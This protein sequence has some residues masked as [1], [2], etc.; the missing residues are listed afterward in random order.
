MKIL[1]INDYATPTGGAEI[2][3]CKVKAGKPCYLNGCLPLRDFL[4]LMVQKKL[5]S[6]KYSVFNLMVANSEMMKNAFIAEGFNVSEV[7]NHGIT[8]QPNRS[9]LP[10]NPIVAFAGRLVPEKGVDILLKAFVEVIKTIPSAKLLIAG[11]GPF[12]KQL[13]HQIMALNLTNHVQM[14]GFIP[15]EN[16]SNTL[17]NAWVQ[18][19]PSLWAEPFG[20]VAAEAMMRGVP[21]IASQTG[22]LQEIVQDGVTGLF[23]PPG[24]ELALSTALIQLLSNRDLVSK[25]GVS[26]RQVALS[27][28]TAE[29]MADK[30][31]EIYQQLNQQTGENS[32]KI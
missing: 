16:L 2:S 28:F 12:E 11:S 1:L 23:I 6:S 15:P 30:F 5:A 19:V 32:D 26:A 14:L 27:K 4:P 10:S 20:M 21:V 17:A 22:G 13:S 3:T 24:D 8:I 9:S 25:M 18:V 31:L 7:I 29:I